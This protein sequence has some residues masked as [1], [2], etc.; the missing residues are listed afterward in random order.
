MAR[1][2]L[3]SEL[4]HIAAGVVQNQL[5]NVQN[6][7]A[8]V[9]NQLANAQ[10]QLVNVQRARENVENELKR[11]RLRDKA[12]STGTAHLDCNFRNSNDLMFIFPV[13]QLC[14]LSSKIFHIFPSGV[15]AKVMILKRLRTFSQVF[16]L[17]LLVLSSFM[18]CMAKKSLVWDGNAS[19][20]P[21]VA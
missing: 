5:A 4:H 21:S 20:L 3:K 16:S 6:Q 1:K 11:R 10:K 19:W 7:L 9:Q 12:F 14:N 13:P 8:N 2:R 15:K 18:F 17:L